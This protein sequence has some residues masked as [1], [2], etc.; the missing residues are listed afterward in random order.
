[1]SIPKIRYRAT[2]LVITVL[3]SAACSSAHDAET[4]L[5]IATIAATS[6]TAPVK[7]DIP[8]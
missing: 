8:L 2:L 4:A 5:T 6:A 3:L 1:M 7:P